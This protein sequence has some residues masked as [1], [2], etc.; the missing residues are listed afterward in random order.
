MK[1]QKETHIIID[2]RKLELL[3]RLGCDEH[4]IFEVICGKKPRS[5]GDKLIDDTLECFVSKRTYKN[6]GGNHNP[7]GKNQYTKNGQ[8]GGQVEGQVDHQKTG[9]LGTITLTPTMTTSFLDSKSSIRNTRASKFTPPTLQEVFEY[10]KQQ[11]E[12]A[13]V[14]GFACTRE[15]AEEFWGNYESNGWVV[16]NESQTPIRDW[17]AKLRQWAVRNRTKT[18]TDDIPTKP[19]EVPLC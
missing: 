11:N 19:K 13:G 3:L 7:Q 8:D 5:S 12:L 9:Q 16:S 2:E 14:G 6:W 1:Y 4:K 15:I 10:A 17:K 18:P